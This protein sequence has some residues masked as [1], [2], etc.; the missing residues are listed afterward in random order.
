MILLFLGLLFSAFWGIRY[1]WLHNWQKGL[2]IAVEMKQPQ[3]FPGEIFTLRQIV[4]NQKNFGLPFLRLLISFDPHFD[5]V[6][7]D[8]EKPIN[9]LFQVFSLASWSRSE[10]VFRI[11]GHKR[12]VYPLTELQLHCRSLL[13]QEAVTQTYPLDKEIMVYPKLVSTQEIFQ[14]LHTSLGEQLAK[15]G[16]VSDPLSFRGLREYH[17]GD[18]IKQLDYKKSAQLNQWMVRQYDP[19]A[20]QEVTLVLDLPETT[21]W[22]G[23]PLAEASISLFASLAK[24]CQQLGYL[25]RCQTNGRNQT[26]QHLFSGNAVAT[27]VILQNCSHLALSQTVPTKDHLLLPSQQRNH[28]CLIVTSAAA[29]S[30]EKARL[31]EE[32]AGTSGIV[33]LA[34]KLA[35]ETTSNG[36][37]TIR[38]WVI[39]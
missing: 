10:K 39:T 9:D 36:K 37:L 29:W 27:S 25:V 38:E 20:N 32:M 5:L 18:A 17:S 21:N 28:N 8:H 2:S 7:A 26:G 23:A 4:F 16:L 14:I 30:S 12:G 22:K 33:L 34:T 13:F 19:T 3:V 24:E 35:Q 11:K 15:Q 6:E 31:A 1:Y